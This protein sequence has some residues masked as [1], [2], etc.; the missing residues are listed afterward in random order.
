MAIV[1][2]SILAPVQ[3]DDPTFNALRYA[4]RLARESGGTLHLLHV[5][6]KYPALGEPDVSENDNIQEETESRVRLTEIAREQLA[7]V[8]YEVH[9]AAAAPRALAKAIVRVADE[10]AADVIVMRTHGRKGV[11]HLVIGSVADEVVRSAACP[12]LTVTP[13]ALQKIVK[14]AA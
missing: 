9:V 7:D 1:F 14:P 12:V 5:T 13:A 11:M 6:E 8:K 4:A 2:K 10:V 3:F